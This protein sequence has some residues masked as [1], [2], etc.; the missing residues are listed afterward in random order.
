[1]MEGMEQKIDVSALIREGAMLRARMKADEIR[2]REISATLAK[3]ASCGENG[4]GGTVA[5]EGCRAVVRRTS[6]VK[7]D[8]QILRS[9]AEKLGPEEFGRVFATVYKPVSAAAYRDWSNDP[10][11]SSENKDLVAQARKVTSTAAAVQFILQESDADGTEA[12]GDAA[13]SSGE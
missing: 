1:N 5:G 9:A 6:S 2:L 8:Q 12:G 11:V 10:A 7:W 4:G 3:L 13:A